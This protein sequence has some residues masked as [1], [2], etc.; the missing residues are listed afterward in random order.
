MIPDDSGEVRMLKKEL[1][2]LRDFVREQTR[3]HPIVVGLND[4]RYHPGD[5]IVSMNDIERTSFAK[6]VSSDMNGAYMEVFWHKRWVQFSAAMVSLST[7]GGFALEIYRML[8][9]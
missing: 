7:L 3:Q 8:K 5:M 1:E 6:R 4:P 2:S 9:P